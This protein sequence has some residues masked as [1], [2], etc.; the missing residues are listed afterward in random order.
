MS[1][2]MRA[3]HAFP[4]AIKMVADEMPDPIAHDFRVLFDETNFG[5]PQQAIVDAHGRPCAG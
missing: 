1:R 2:A 5:V 4:T 3:G